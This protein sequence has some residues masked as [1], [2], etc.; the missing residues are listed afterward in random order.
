MS[1]SVAT[2]NYD[3]WRLRY[4]E[5]FPAVTPFVAQEYFNEACLYLDNSG[6]GQVTN[7]TTQLTLLNMLTAHIAALA[8]QD[9]VGRVTDATEGSVSVSASIGDAVPLSAGWFQQTK[10]RSE[11]RRVGKEC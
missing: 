3:T 5:F 1:A 9:L 6:Y 7:A 4:P 10:Y 11:E 2:F 8:N